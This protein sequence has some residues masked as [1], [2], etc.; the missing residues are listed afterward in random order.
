MRDVLM[1]LRS[2]GDQ[3][4]VTSAWSVVGDGDTQLLRRFLRH[5][6]IQHFVE[7]PPEVL[8]SLAALDD[9]IRDRQIRG[10]TRD[11]TSKREAAKA[12]FLMMDVDT[13]N[14]E[15]MEAL[16]GERPARAERR[17]TRIIE[18]I[19]AALPLAVRVA[20]VEALA[21]ER[22]RTEQGLPAEQDAFRS[23][24]ASS[25]RKPRPRSSARSENHL[26]ALHLP[27]PGDER[28]PP[29]AHLSSRPSS[30]STSVCVG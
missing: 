30:S 20:L 28:P 12:F 26:R 10:R 22:S 29:K 17:R 24:R 27:R 23:C 2:W 3:D 5:L 4:R 21:E 9:R 19:E 18:K 16:L 13:A 6:D 14:A 25:A 7:F 15:E 1:I 11:I 8:A